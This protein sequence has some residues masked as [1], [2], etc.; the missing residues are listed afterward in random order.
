MRTEKQTTYI[1]THDG[2]AL[3][4]S[5]KKLLEG[6]KFNFFIMKTC[7]C[8][9]QR[10]FHKQKLK[11]SLKKKDIFNIFAQNIDRGCT[12]EPP[13]QGSS[14]EYMYPQS[15]FWIKNKNK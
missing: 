4:W 2:T 1:D 3:I 5:G 12:L 13:H 10:I 7:L 11:F 14:K 15:M 6:L 8:N 9:I